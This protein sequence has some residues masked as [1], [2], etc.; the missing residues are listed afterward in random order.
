MEVPETKRRRRRGGRGCG[1]RRRLLEQ[2]K[3]LPGLS[4]QRA[5][6]V[7]D[8]LVGQR[9]VGP[10]GLGN[11]RIGQ[12]LLKGQ[13]APAEVEADVLHERRPVD[14]Y[15]A[16]LKPRSVRR[17]AGQAD[18]E[19]GLGDGRV[20]KELA[21]GLAHLA[22]LGLAQP[23]PSRAQHV[24]EAGLIGV[25]QSALLWIAECALGKPLQQGLSKT[26]RQVDDEI[27]DDCHL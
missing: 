22:Q 20:G 8:D 15:P 24:L 12:A 2:G 25:S 21:N 27:L 7:D 14:G 16:L 11:Q 1:L 6:P 4:L 5:Q 23:R 17:R 19:Q 26:S 13:H 10:A 9:A 3:D 18:V